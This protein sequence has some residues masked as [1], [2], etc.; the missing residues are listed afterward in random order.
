MDERIEEPFNNAIEKG[1]LKLDEIID[2]KT[3]K[4]NKKIS[5]ESEK[6][7][8]FR[9]FNDKEELDNSFF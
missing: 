2:K 9:R 8:R 4:D 6:M 5:D 1:V 3:K 7:G